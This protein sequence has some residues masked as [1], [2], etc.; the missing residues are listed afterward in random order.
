MKQVHTDALVAIRHLLEVDLNQVT[1]QQGQ[2]AKAALEAKPST[3][4]LLLAI[5]AWARALAGVCRSHSAKCAEI[6]SVCGGRDPA[7]AAMLT[8]IP[9]L[10]EHLRLPADLANPLLALTAEDW[11]KSNGVRDFV[12]DVTGAPV[13][14][15]EG[16]IVTKAVLPRWEIKSGLGQMM[17]LLRTDALEEK[18]AAFL[19]VKETEKRLRELERSFR[20]TLRENLQT[21]YSEA[22]L[23]TH[24]SPQA[25]HALQPGKRSGPKVRPRTKVLREILSK[26]PDLPCKDVCRLMDSKFATNQS[27]YPTLAR[28]EFCGRTY[29]SWEQAY[30]DKSARNLV[31]ALIS[32]S[33]PKTT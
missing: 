31:E 3:L 5:K 33:R 7:V 2:T 26:Q 21:C 32:R 15:I 23:A 29:H 10:C 18:N 12:L 6:Q 27:R 1:F 30:S 28:P 13:H 20:N 22:A 14:L 17:G 8:I 24:K 9:A 4:G 19:S 25:S 11:P 16:E